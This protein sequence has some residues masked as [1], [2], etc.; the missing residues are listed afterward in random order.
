M[1]GCTI[2]LWIYLLKWFLYIYIYIYIF[3]Y[4]FIH[5]HTY[6]YTYIIYIYIYIYIWCIYIYVTFISQYIQIFWFQSTF[7]WPWH[8]H[9]TTTRESP[10]A[11]ALAWLHPGRNVC[12]GVIYQGY[13]YRSYTMTHALNHPESFGEW[14]KVMLESWYAI[15]ESSWI[16]L[17]HLESSWSSGWWRTV[18]KLQWCSGCFIPE[19][20]QAHDIVRVSQGICGLVRLVR[21]VTTRPTGPS[22]S[23]GWSSFSPMNRVVLRGIP[24]L[25]TRLGALENPHRNSRAASDL[26]LLFGDVRAWHLFYDSST[27]QKRNNNSHGPQIE[28]PDTPTSV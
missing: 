20:H 23:H 14:Q 12:R 8:R 7:T 18:A 16:I 4:I 24:N 22:R 19:V 9:Q 13:V 2:R 26:H 28:E 25:S 3:T 1:T 6:I 17:N 21:L 11:S 27:S 15:L 10:V 5:I